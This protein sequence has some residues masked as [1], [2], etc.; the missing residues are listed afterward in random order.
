ML[1]EHFKGRKANAWCAANGT[2]WVAEASQAER[3]ECKIAG[4]AVFGS[5]YLL[6][7][8]ASMT[9]RLSHHL[10]SQTQKRAWQGIAT[11]MFFENRLGRLNRGSANGHLVHA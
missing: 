5:L 1:D 8:R 7:R 6:Q 2:P 9:A 11:P 4:R 10:N 3:T